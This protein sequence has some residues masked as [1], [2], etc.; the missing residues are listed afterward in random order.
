ML[1]CF[2]LLVAAPHNGCALSLRPVI[3]YVMREHGV[4]LAS[5]LRVIPNVKLYAIK[6]AIHVGGSA[7]LKIRLFGC[8]FSG[9]TEVSFAGVVL[10]HLTVKRD[11]GAHRQLKP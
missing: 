9:L 10:W 11:P 8:L 4:C 2:T 3:Q 5:C 7:K 6:I 1:K